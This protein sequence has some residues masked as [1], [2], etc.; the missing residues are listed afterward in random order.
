MD[1]KALAKAEADIALLRKALIGLVGAD[2]KE[3]LEQIAIGLDLIGGLVEGDVHDKE[4]AFTAV[5]AL[6]A[7]MPNNKG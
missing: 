4:A 3:E 7:T 6:L 5:N 2:T 1:N